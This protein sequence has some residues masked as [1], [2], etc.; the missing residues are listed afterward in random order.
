MDNPLVNLTGSELGT[1]SNPISSSEVVD[2][3]TQGGVIHTLYKHTVCGALNELDGPTA[4]KFHIDPTFYGIVHCKQC[5]KFRPTHE[6]RWFPSGQPLN[7][8]IK[9]KE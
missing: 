7:S 1:I 4:A 6:F 3:S 5:K 2:K 8:I 9:N